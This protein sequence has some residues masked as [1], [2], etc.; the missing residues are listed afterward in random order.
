[1]K[2]LVI[3]L[4]DGQK[5]IVVVKKTNRV[6]CTGFSNDKKHDFKLFKEI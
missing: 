3:A 6:I 4:V 5:I 2:V 1:V